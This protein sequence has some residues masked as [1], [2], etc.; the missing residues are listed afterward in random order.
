MAKKQ[1]GTK[2]RLTRLGEKIEAI[3]YPAPKKLTKKD[4]AKRFKLKFWLIYIPIFLTIIALTWYLKSANVQMLNPE[5]SIGLA[6]RNLIVFTTVLAAF[7]VIPVFAMT[8]YIAKKYSV[9][10]KSKKKY[11]PTWDTNILAEVIWWGI[12]II[13]IGIVAATAW[14][15]TYKLDPYKPLA[16]DRPALNIQVISLDWKWLFIYPDQ[17]IATINYIQFPKDRPVTFAITSDTVMNSFWIPRL[18][19]Q[20]YAMP[21]M[22]TKLNMNATKFGDYP[23][24]AA[25]ITGE[26]FA[27]MTFTAR[28]SSDE[29]FNN[30]V[31][32]AQKAN[33]VLDQNNYEKLLVKSK[34][35]PV[36][37]YSGID[38]DL[39]QRI[40]MKYMHPNVDTSSDKTGQEDV[41]PTDT[42]NDNLGHSMPMED[43]Q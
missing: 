40:I 22:Q 27:G 36:S 35:D 3:L 13:I 24:S 39:F 5:G 9:N 14:I 26:G 10:N 21:G 15:S 12:P 42:N 8:I 7:V 6:Q 4:Q 17:K 38:P 2:E 16:S 29:E 25:N 20:I 33:R 28:V 18:S 19:G 41:T 30:W 43:M 23:G 11:T 34:N 37:L 1:R 32:K 31:K